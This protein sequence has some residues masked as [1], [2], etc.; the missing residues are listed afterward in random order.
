MFNQVGCLILVTRRDFVLR[1]GA[2]IFQSGLFCIQAVRLFCFVTLPN[3]YSG[4]VPFMTQNKFCIQGG[5]LY[6]HEVTWLS[7]PIGALI[8]LIWSNFV[9]NMGAF[10]FMTWPDFVYRLGIFLFLSRLDF[11]LGSGA[12][13]CMTELDF[14]FRSSAFVGEIV[15][16]MHHRQLFRGYFMG[17]LFGPFLLA[18]L[19]VYLFLLPILV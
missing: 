1:L 10:V 16:G 18:Y 8:F 14:G 12:F 9:P 2:F 7:V 17:I 15:F 5:C 19:G 6:F 4:Q 13:S 3:L 11:L